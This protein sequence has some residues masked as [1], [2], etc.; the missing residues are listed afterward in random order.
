MYI[1]QAVEYPERPVPV[2]QVQNAWTGAGLPQPVPTLPG[3]AAGPAGVRSI[4]EG[5]LRT[6]GATSAN[7]DFE[8]PRNQ[9]EALEKLEEFYHRVYPETRGSAALG[10]FHYEEVE[11]LGEF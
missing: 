5:A 11:W 2:A 4:L 10:H 7:G 9:V 6:H 8:V 1:L 3:D